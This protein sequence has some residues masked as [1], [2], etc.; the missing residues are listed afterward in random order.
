MNVFVN[1]LFWFA[2]IIFCIFISSELI[3]IIKAFRIE[4]DKHPRFAEIEG[5]NIAK[6]ILEIAIPGIPISFIT[7]LLSLLRLEEVK[8][9]IFPSPIFCFLAVTE[10]I[11]PF[12][13]VWVVYAKAFL[14]PKK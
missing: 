3:P 11:A 6:K 1:P 9:G 13:F 4:Q 14:L 5:H 10:I 8:E 12:I 2:S 7:F